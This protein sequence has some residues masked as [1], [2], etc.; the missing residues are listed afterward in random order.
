MIQVYD[1][2][3]TEEQISDLSSNSN[4]LEFSTIVYDENGTIPLILSTEKGV[5]VGEIQTEI[6]NMSWDDK[7]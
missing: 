2:L 4:N 7:Q 5:S 1:K 3:L 6:K